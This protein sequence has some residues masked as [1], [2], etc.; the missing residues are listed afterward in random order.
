M[1]SILCY[2]DSNTWGAIPGKDQRYTYNCRWTGIVQNRLG[3]DFRIIE[4]GLGG[5][6]TAL[7]DPF[8]SGRNGL[9]ILP[10]IL[11]TH[12]PLDL[13]IISLG[14]NDLKSR[15]NFTPIN[16]A[17]GIAK[18]LDVCLMNN[19]NPNQI[20]IISPPH[21]VKGEDEE[22]LLG[23]EGAIE[24]SKDLAENYKHVSN[25]YSCHFLDS[26]EIITSSKVDG[27]HLE[28]EAHQKLGEAIA[29][30][31]RKIF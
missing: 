21:I 26:A 11:D 31:I 5:R 28:L 27:I 25:K 23:W 10:I 13:I 18:L 19:L 22:S 15:F 29:E 24:K 3:N 20:M 8:C 1:K 17:Q 14:T 9:A 2:G 6:T 30:K 16:T 4:E 7:E 12:A